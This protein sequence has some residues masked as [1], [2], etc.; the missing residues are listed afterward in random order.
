MKKWISILMILLVLLAAMTGC[1]SG[2]GQK[3]GETQVTVEESGQYDSKDQVSAYL[4]QYG[5]LPDNYITKKEARKLGWEGGSLEPYAPG[6]CIGGD[7]FGNREEKLPEDDYQECDIDTMGADSRGAKRIV[8]SDDG[9]IYYTEDHY[10]S[11][12]QLAE[13]D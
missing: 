5:H 1:Q 7:H 8:F 10:Q 6:K 2:E 11:F 12:E 13:G 3:S 9:D 4:Q